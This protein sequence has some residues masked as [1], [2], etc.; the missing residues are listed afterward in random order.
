MDRSF[1]NWPEGRAERGCLIMITTLRGWVERY[2][3]RRAL[4][5]DWKNGNSRGKKKHRHSFSGIHSDRPIMKTRLKE[6]AD[7]DTANCYREQSY[8]TAAQRQEMRLNRQRRW[9]FR[10]NRKP[11]FGQAKR[12]SSS[13]GTMGALCCFSSGSR[14]PTERRKEPEGRLSPPSA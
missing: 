10:L 2:G 13:N 3:I 12:R 11:R 1:E 6:I 4:Y 7:Y 8:F 9:T 5:V 14:C